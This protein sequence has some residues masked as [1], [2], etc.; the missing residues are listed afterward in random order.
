MRILLQVYQKQALEWGLNLPEAIV[1]NY[2]FEATAWAD[3]VILAGHPWYWVSR[4]KAASDLLLLS[5]TAREKV[6]RGE[7]ITASDADTFYRHYKSLEKK[8]LIELS[9]VEGKDCFKFTEKARNWGTSEHS[10][11]FPTN[12][13]YNNTIDSIYVGK[14]SEQSEVPP[15]QLNLPP[16]ERAIQQAIHK[17]KAWL[18]EWP[19]MKKSLMDGAKAKEGDLDFMA[20]LESWVRHNSQNLIFMQ[21]PTLAIPKSFAMWLMRSKQWASPI[22]K[23]NQTPSTYRPKGTFSVKKPRA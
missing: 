9:L 6:E 19:A 16:E 11:K 17:C 21:N 10:E 1:F 18:N 13:I 23:E 5:K 15:G 20:E 4:V 7:K 2:L 8:G 12:T 3:T 14:I 22:K